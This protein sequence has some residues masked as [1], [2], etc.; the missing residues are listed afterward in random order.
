[1]YSVKIGTVIRLVEDA[2]KNRFKDTLLMA[3]GEQHKSDSLFHNTQVSGLKVQLGNCEIRNENLEQQLQTQSQI[4]DDVASEIGIYKKS[5]RRY[6]MQR[7]IIA[8]FLILVA[9]AAIANN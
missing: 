4:H 5:S 6:R 1:M 9:G 2:Y 7:N 3:M 8:G